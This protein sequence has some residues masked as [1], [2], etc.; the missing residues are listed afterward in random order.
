M[1]KLRNERAFDQR[2]DWYLRAARGI[3]EYQWFL[4]DLSKAAEARN[5]ARVQDLMDK[6]QETKA[7]QEAVQREMALF[8]S[9]PTIAALNR[10]NTRAGN[11]LKSSAPAKEVADA[12]GRELDNAYFVLANDI[13]K[14]LGMEPLTLQDLKAMTPDSANTKPDK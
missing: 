10:A 4:I 6:R 14:H 3:V 5:S 11:A 9:R 7:G 8:A 1:E 12:A 13:R 2:L